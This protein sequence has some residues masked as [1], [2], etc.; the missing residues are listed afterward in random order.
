[1]SDAGKG[2]PQG[3]QPVEDPKD[4]Q[5]ALRDAAKE[6]AEATIWSENQQHLIN[7]HVTVVDIPEGYLWAWTPKDYDP[8]H[9]MD[10]LAR[11]K[12][13]DLYFSV[14]MS[15][16]VIFFK[17]KFHGF[18]GKGLK[19]GLPAKIF[20]VQRRKD[21]RFPIPDGHVLKLDY[22]DPLFPD[23]RVT[24]KA[25]D[26]SAGGISFVVREGEDAVYQEGLDLRGISFALRGRKITCDGV[27]KHIK[28]LSARSRAQGIKIGVEFTKI[29]PSD[30]HY[31]AAY[32]FEESRKYF[33]RLV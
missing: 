18:D 20:K 1:L 13:S 6:F 22:E 11:R 4:A 2:A 7:S 27:I 15:R 28:P 14:S 23:S 12:I 32:V 5:A 21:F 31:I 29:N 3:F 9:L 33:S 8:K 10:D 19:F 24:R 17:T 26:L 25:L 30:A 16:S